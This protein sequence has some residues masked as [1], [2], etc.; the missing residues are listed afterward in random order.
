MSALL[1]KL[2]RDLWRLRGQAFAI[3]IVIGAATATFVLALSVYRS[4]EETRDIYYAR[5]HFGE[6]FANM[7]RAPRNIVPRAAGI[8]GVRRAEGR[9]VQYVTIDMPG[10]PTPVRGVI[11]SVGAAGATEL[12]RIQ[13][14]AGRGPGLDRSEEV[15]V[16]RTFAEANGLGLGDTLDTLIYGTR[17]RLRIVGIGM[18]PDYI[19]AIAPGELIP[20]ETRFG[21]FWMGEEALE[22]ATDR[23]EAINAL[24]L[25][26]EPGA[27]EAEVIRQLDQLLDRYGGSGAYGREDHLSH[28][29]LDSDLAQ[30]EALALVIP[31]VFLLVSVFLVYVVLGRL[32]RT[33][34]EQIGLMKAFGYSNTAIGWHYLQL[35]LAI[36]LLG[37]L[38]GSLAG[39]WMGRGMTALY[40][41]FYR[42]PLL[43][44]RVTADV[45][46]I[47]AGLAF[48][49][50]ALGAFGGVRSAVRLTPAVAMSPPPP[51]NYR[52]GLLERHGQRLG[53]TSIGQ[54]IARHII[55]WP[56]RSAMTVVGVALSLGL[57]FSTMQFTD[58]S[59]AMLDDYFF[60][61]QRQDLTVSFIEPRNEDVL[62]ELAQ[63]PGVLRVEP[64]RAA[65]A[66]L[67]NGA[68]SERVAIESAGADARLW[69]RIDAD[70]REIPLPASGLMLSGLL[71]DKLD[72]AVGETVEV[73]L[74]EGRRLTR[75]AEV[76]R[77]ID[78]L[79]GT[80]AYADSATLARLTRDE[81][82]VGSALLSIDAN[83]RAAILEALGDMPIVLGVTEQQAA[84]VRFEELVDENINTSLIFYVGFAS[85]IVVG[86]VYNSARLLF[87]ERAR[88]LATLRVLGYH[89]REVAVVM[90]GEIALLVV[91]ALP[92][93]ILMGYWLAQLM[94]ALFSSDL[95]RLPF[96][97][98]RATYGYATL[99]VIAAAALTA[100]VVTRRVRRLDMVRVLKA[101][102]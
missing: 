30:L 37:V 1:L 59:L 52:A 7:T 2:L 84:L 26:L 93:G 35:A 96:A 17:K 5:A 68:R 10:E 69:A 65:A 71:A 80:R 48:A 85:A 55:R 49:S 83:R 74:L 13:L 94:T 23:T 4:L 63:L 42:F 92:I 56:G 38:I 70:G 72:L 9:I 14:V 47:G 53:F 73:E 82:M 54:M 76:T 8:E 97:P 31:P 41:E 16:D 95:F 46:A 101:R 50:A 100:L 21:I 28:A 75:R 6:V 89:R 87:S 19:W 33:E 88:E 45:L 90:L 25:T 67:R 40:A 64:I 44:Y 11:N 15:V 51:A 43:H 58:A 61:A 81:A 66:R 62:Y 60:R 39:A 102:D 32:I 86:V 78:E 99:V 27:P 29:F 22:A 98:R 12:N 57:L 24:S 18:A 79:V 3:A 36:A 20:D 91:I 77:T 34:R